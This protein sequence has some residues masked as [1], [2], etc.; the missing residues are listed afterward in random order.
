MEYKISKLKEITTYI[1][2][3]ITPKYTE[4]KENGIVVLNQKCIRDYRINYKESKMHNI[5]EKKVS[6]EK[7]G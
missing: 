7:T 1:A 6:K 4:D 5:K 3:G 2:R